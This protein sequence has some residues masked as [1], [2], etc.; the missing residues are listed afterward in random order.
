MGLDESS[1]D[2]WL[3][4]GAAVAAEAT[5]AEAT[6]AEATDAEATDEPEER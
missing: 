5:N 3:R 6:D 4:S 1:I 2:G